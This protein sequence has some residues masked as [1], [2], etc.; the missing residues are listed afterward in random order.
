[1]MQQMVNGSDQ[2]L[3]AKAIEALENVKA[4]RQCFERSDVES[5]KGNKGLLTF[6]SNDLLTG[7]VV[8][9]DWDQN[10]G[11]FRMRDYAMPNSAPIMDWCCGRQMQ[12]TLIGRRAGSSYRWGTWVDDD[13]REEAVVELLDRSG[14]RFE[15]KVGYKRFAF[16]QVA[17]Y[18]PEPQ[19]VSDYVIRVGSI[20]L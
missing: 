18:L 17:E 19:Q 13:E 8:L 12:V 1:M 10:T 5:C 6:S 2:E 11:L 4:L 9:I 14:A 7:D 3:R 20:R 16:L 15:D